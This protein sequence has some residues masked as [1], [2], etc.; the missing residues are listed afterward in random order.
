MQSF[1]I[2]LLCREPQSHF[3]F[4]IIS[5]ESQEKTGRTLLKMQQ[6]QGRL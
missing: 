1:L 6:P 5:M 3:Y 4:R 2:C